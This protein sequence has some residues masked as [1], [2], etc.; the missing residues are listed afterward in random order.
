M[1]SAAEN[2][3]L[4]VDLA[5]QEMD[6]RAR[7]RGGDWQEFHHALP[8]SPVSDDDYRADME[9]ARKQWDY[10]DRRPMGPKEPAR[11]RISD[12]SLERRPVTPVRNQ[13]IFDYPPVLRPGHSPQAIKPTSPIDRRQRPPHPPKELAL[14]SL[15]APLI[16]HKE[17]LIPVSSYSQ[18]PPS[19]AAPTRP[20][21]EP[22][23]HEM[24]PS[25]PAT[26]PTS[27]L[28]NLAAP[29]K[30]ERVS[31]QPS[32]RLE[33]GAP[34]RPVFLPADIRSKFLEL[35]Y[36]NTRRGLEMCGILCGSLVNDAFFVTTLLIPNQKCTSDTC[37]TE[38]EDLTLAYCLEN[39]L[40]VV[41]WI[42]THPT[43]S[44]FM[45]SRDL[46][47]HA[48]YQVMM[49]ESIAIVCAPRSTPSSVELFAIFSKAL[50]LT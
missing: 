3:D 1:L 16:P 31:F 43:Q 42:H 41:G 17:P 40:I 14:R 30:K 5:R 27:L 44:C 38:D 4:A 35:A 45:S 22:P 24:M 34:L 49:P 6:K 7:R 13:G 9:S 2:Q 33:N 26:S 47:T 15:Q 46:H 8:A 21:K 37:E 10:R 32:A 39:D 23:T 18:D 19:L 12:E 11:S 28:P 25:V 29:S 48:G 36:A 50:T 20:P